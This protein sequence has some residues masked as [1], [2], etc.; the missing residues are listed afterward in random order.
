MEMENY[1]IFQNLAVEREQ[2]TH[3][4]RNETYT[5]FDLIQNSLI[6]W[7]QLYQAYRCNEK[8][9]AI[10]AHADHLHVSSAVHSNGVR[11]TMLI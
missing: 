7:S 3:P 4:V 11:M 5:I 1:M 10:L 9:L 2:A 8:C 6:K